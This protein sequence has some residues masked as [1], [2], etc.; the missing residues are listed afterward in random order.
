MINKMLVKLY[1]WLT[2]L[3][4]HN[5]DKLPRKKG[6]ITKYFGCYKKCR[7]CGKTKWQ[8]MINDNKLN[9]I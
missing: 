1:E 4:W 3:C 8:L 7:K 6:D 9:Y 5:Y 2:G